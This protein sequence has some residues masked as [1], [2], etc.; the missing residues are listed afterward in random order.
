MLSKSISLDPSPQPSP[1][2]AL[3]HRIILSPALLTLSLGIKQLETTS[4]PPKPTGI[5]QN[6]QS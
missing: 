5:T 1:L 4:V 2:S 3:I 6:S